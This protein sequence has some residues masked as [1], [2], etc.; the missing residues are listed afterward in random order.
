MAKSASRDSSVS[1]QDDLL[2]PSNRPRLTE[3]CSAERL[4][5][6]D[7]LAV[8]SIRKMEES[9]LRT[10]MCQPLTLRRC[11]N[12]A[13]PN[14][15]RRALGSLPRAV[16]A[17]ASIPLLGLQRVQ[18]RI[19]LTRTSRIGKEAE[20]QEDVVATRDRSLLTKRWMIKRETG[21]A[22]RKAELQQV[23]CL[24]AGEEGTDG[25]RDGSAEVDVGMLDAGPGHPRAKV[26]GRKDNSHP[27]NN[28]RTN[29]TYVL[30]AHPP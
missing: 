1:P 12:P 15:V 3:Q 17:S 18:I 25:G 19:S 6:P 4:S 8:V 22:S 21:V 30:S 28:V 9:I 2:D 10:M 5:R 20:N 16:L 27:W 26:M 14:Q 23:S 11:K 7:H 29:N 13:A 24:S